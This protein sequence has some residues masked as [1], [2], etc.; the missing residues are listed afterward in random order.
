MKRGTKPKPKSLLHLQGGYRP[1]RH[2]GGLDI[3]PGIPTAPRG[4]GKY[5]RTEWEYVTKLLGELNILSKADRAALTMYCMAWE[6][7]WRAENLVK[8]H[9]ELVKTATGELKRNPATM[10]R[11]KAWEHVMKSAAEF[12]LTPSAR[13]SVDPLGDGAKEEDPFDE[14][15]NRGKRHG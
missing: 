4:L 6:H 13:R 10:I 8:K 3:E 9:G 5:G 14:L 11:D 2:S 15:V 7:Y 1:D 12:G